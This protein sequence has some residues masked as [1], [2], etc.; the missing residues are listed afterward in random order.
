MKDSKNKLPP[1]WAEI[2]LGKLITN[3]ASVNPKS[4]PIRMFELWSVPSFETGFPEFVKGAEVGSNKQEV[5]PGDV[6]LCKINPRINRVW[7]VGERADFDQIASTEWIVL[8]S[9][10]LYQKFILYQLREDG[11]RQRLLVDLSG[12]GGSLTR[13]RPRIVGQL[14][15]KLAPLNEQKRIV[16]R[17]E[18]LQAHSQ[19]AREALEAIPDL[20]E[21]LRQSTLAA[22]FLGD[23]TKEWR[24]KHQDVEPASELLKRIHT[25]R[26]KRWEE[27][28]REKLKTKGLSGDKLD[29]EFAKR[30]KKYKESAPVDTS[31]LPELPDGWCVTSI[32]AVAFVTKLAGFEYT[33]Y[34]TYDPDGDL[35]V[36]KAENAGKYGF[37]RTEFSKVRSR[38]IDHLTRSNLRSG[39]LLMV[40]VGAGVGQVAMV[41]DDQK[42]FL[43]PNIGM[44]RIQSR[45]VIPAFAE[46]FLRS[47]I[48][49][50]FT[51]SFAK[52]VA[53]SSLSMG[54]IR[55]IPLFIPPLE[56]QKIIVEKLKK[57]NDIIKEREEKTAF[58]FKSVQILDQSIFSKAFRGELVP[59]DPNDEPASILL[60]RIRQAKAREA[61]QPKA[62]DKQKG[63]KM[64][65]KQEEQRDVIAVLRKSGKA[66]TP[67][68]V[69]SA[70]GFDEASVDIFYEQLR[71]SIASKLVREI[72]KDK[73][74][75]LEVI[76]P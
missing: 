62:K 17:I 35:S 68:E 30:R 59:Q 67:E 8:R 2:K 23:L 53:Q 74:I 45:Y 40:F 29:E 20:L 76:T 47:P 1:G 10:N 24:E 56:E 25:E 42:Y 75:W 46:F 52:A 6:L 13:A 12:I 36:I 19:R 14:T 28:E 18:E 22:A 34:V 37:K 32:D 31:D 21:Q 43:G 55:L 60:E 50:S 11:F 48:G 64:K 61:V 16:A 66:L 41:P 72:R 65:H 57:Y 73:T 44:I 27:A 58:F 39:D 38:T 4:L 5:T 49:F 26:R 70:A 51:M 54:A 69:F 33:K 3:T 9:T 15:L 63:M 7:L 71:E